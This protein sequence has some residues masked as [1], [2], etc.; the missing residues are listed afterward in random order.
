M[1]LCVYM[2]LSVC[3]WGAYVFV[4]VCALLVVRMWNTYIHV[5]FIVAVSLTGCV[6]FCVASLSISACVCRT[7]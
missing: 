6:H 1:C 4:S 3:G 5:H 2:Y 7:L